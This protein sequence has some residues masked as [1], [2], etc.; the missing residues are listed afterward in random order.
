V[1][2]GLNAMGCQ[3][4]QIELSRCHARLAGHEPLAD[5]PPHLRL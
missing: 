3:A 5:R 4:R 1:R 2:Q